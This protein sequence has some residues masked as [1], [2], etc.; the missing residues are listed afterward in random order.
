MIYFIMPVGS[1][2]QFHHKRRILELALR[3]VDQT[4]HFPL[5]V[6][7]GREFSLDSALQDMRAADLIIGDLALERPS[8]YFEVGLAQA[9]GLYVALVAPV[10]TPIHQVSGR[11]RVAFYS[12]DSSYEA[13]I[14][15]LLRRNSGELLHRPRG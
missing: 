6:N 13:V 2:P 4:G 11:G 12:N 14:R 10:G 1:D 5:E 15:E 3:D 8:C 7:T 9:A